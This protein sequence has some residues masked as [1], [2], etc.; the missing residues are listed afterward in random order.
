MSSIV[1]DTGALIALENDDRRLWAT[2]KAAAQDRRRVLVPTTVVAQVWRAQVQQVLLARALALCSLAPFDPI[3]RD[4]GRLCA[5]SATKDIVDAHV[6]IVAATA[7]AVFTSDP[8]DLKHL[9][10]S[11]GRKMPRIVHC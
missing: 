6:A 7:D 11:R 3:A 5:Q 2:L 9:F 10:M 1:F 4:I 8:D